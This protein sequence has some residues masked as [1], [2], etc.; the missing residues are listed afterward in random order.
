LNKKY[1]DH[2]DRN[3][4]NNTEANLRAANGSEN[5]MNKGIRT[6]NTSSKV[7]VHK[8]NDVQLFV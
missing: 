8:I 3:K 2:R 5:Q 6:D 7:G 4:L 1:A